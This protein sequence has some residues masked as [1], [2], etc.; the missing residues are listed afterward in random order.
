MLGIQR[1]RRVRQREHD[2]QRR[3]GARSGRTAL[4]LGERWER[5]CVRANVRRSSLLGRQ[6]RR[7]TW[8]RRHT[9]YIDSGQG[10]WRTYVRFDLRRCRACLWI[11]CIWNGI[12]LGRKCQR[13]P[14]TWLCERVCSPHTRAGCR[15]PDVAR[16]ECWRHDVR[17]R[18][19]GSQ[20]LLG[21][22]PVLASRGWKLDSVERC[23]GAGVG[24]SCL[25]HDQGARCRSRV[26][27][28]VRQSRVLLGRLRLVKRRCHAR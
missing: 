19:D 25:S 6:P 26:R 18:N 22:Q 20:L 16:C 15:R 10:E 24:W 14:R 3:A 12:L 8:S 11:D 21:K 7:R 17:H 4:R 23:P 1:I 9:D 27:T 28:R 5:L 13:G 2:L